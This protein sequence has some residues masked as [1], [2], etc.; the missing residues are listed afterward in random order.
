MRIRGKEKADIKAKKNVDT[1]STDTSEEIQ[2]LA[3]AR[4]VIRQKKDKAWLKEWK[5]KGA[6]Q[7]VKY[8]QELK[9]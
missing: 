4:R 6:L 2:T 9:I 1:L 3:Y 7:V 5:T 8:Y